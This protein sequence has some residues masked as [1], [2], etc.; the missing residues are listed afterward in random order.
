MLYFKSKIIQEKYTTKRFQG[1]EA[2]TVYSYG[3]L[4]GNEYVGVQTEYSPEDVIALQSPECEV[5][6]TEYSELANIAINSA[7]AKGIDDIVREKI[8]VIIP[9]ADEEAK[10]INK[11]IQD[12]N[13]PAYVEYRAYVDSC[14]LWGREKKAEMGIIC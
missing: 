8:H 14:I 12:K 2:V 6:E 5:E 13:D 4:G 9:N 3:E 1:N 11:G 10:L 7:I